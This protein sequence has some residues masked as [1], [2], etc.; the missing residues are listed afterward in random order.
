M[1]APQAGIS[2]ALEGRQSLGALSALRPAARLGTPAS[3]LSDEMPIGLQKGIVMT[4]L[5]NAGSLKNDK[6]F[7]MREIVIDT[8]TTGLDSLRLKQSMRQEPQPRSSY[9]H[10]TIR[11]TT[12]AVSAES[13]NMSRWVSSMIKVERVS[14]MGR[15]LAMV[16]TAL[17][18]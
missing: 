12:A 13:T 5:R 16:R 7:N 18:E 14:R 2:G 17:A 4:M 9:Q 6:K 8:E 10:R 11:V 3:S 15:A 1:K